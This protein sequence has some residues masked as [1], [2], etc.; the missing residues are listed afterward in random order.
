MS[1]VLDW[2]D[3]ATPFVGWLELLVGLVVFVLTA[4][5]VVASFGEGLLAR[6][7]TSAGWLVLAQEGFALL[8]EE[9]DG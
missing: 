5:G 3:R 9:G 4:T 6:L 2:F 7:A 8:A 1:S